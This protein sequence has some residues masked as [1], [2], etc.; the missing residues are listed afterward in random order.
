[1][2]C[3][4]LKTLFRIFPLFLAESV[5]SKQLS[6]TPSAMFIF[7]VAFL[8]H[9]MN[10]LWEKVQWIL[11]LYMKQIRIQSKASIV[12]PV[13]TVVFIDF[14]LKK[15]NLFSQHIGKKNEYMNSE[16]ITC[17]WNV[18]LVLVNYFL[19]YHLMVQH[20]P[21]VKRVN[22][23]HEWAHRPYQLLSAPYHCCLYRYRRQDERRPPQSN[24]PVPIC[25]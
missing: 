5:H 6:E 2:L 25:T 11:P 17:N 20:Q 4:D 16:Q 18:N 19:R 1:M 14:G 12:C 21:I 22:G 24:S 23:A 8:F 13:T 3:E 7:H 10:M 9:T 15:L